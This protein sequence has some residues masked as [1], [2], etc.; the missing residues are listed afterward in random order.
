MKSVPTFTA[1]IYVGMREQYTPEVRALEMARE[2]LHDYVNKTGL[3][4]ALTPTEF[5]Y[6]GRKWPDGSV[7]NVGEPGFTVGIINYPRFPSDPEAIKATALTIADGLLRLYKQ[8]KV[9]VV[10]PDV[11][12]MVEQ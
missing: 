3:C 11:T 2:W 1:T 5:I 6:T 7:T 8:F 10:L 4:V 12:I 9:T